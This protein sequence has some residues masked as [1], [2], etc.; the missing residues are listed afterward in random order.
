[1][2]WPIALLA[3]AGCGAPPTA[4]PSVARGA[5]DAGTGDASV[6][7]PLGADGSPLA[8]LDAIASHGATDAPL[9]REVLRADR[10]APRS[11]EVKA[12]RDLCVR[13][14]FAAT[15]TVRIAFV[16]ATGSARGEATTAA[17]G[18]VP[19][20]GPVCIKKG[21]AIHLVVEGVAGRGDAATRAVVFAA[22]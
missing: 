12:D 16:D 3:L 15:A 1:M 4:P 9:M 6:A 17:S 5:S 18:S 20:R 21:E 19:P 13:A 8:S 2:R 22:P 14:L 7:E 11:P 10:A